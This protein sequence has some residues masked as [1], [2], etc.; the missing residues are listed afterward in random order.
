MATNK[1]RILITITEDM[2]KAIQDYRFSARG[3][4]YSAAVRSLIDIGLEKVMEEI[5]TPEGL[6]KLRQRLEAANYK[7]FDKTDAQ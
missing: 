2:D 4:T 3:E 7:N 6:E 5:S 1:P